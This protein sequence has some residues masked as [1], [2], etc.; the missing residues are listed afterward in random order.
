MGRRSERLD[1]FAIGHPSSYD[2]WPMLWFGVGWGRVEVTAHPCPDGWWMRC[3]R[4]KTGRLLAME[5]WPLQFVQDGGR[6]DKIQRVRN[7]IQRFSGSPGGG[8]PCDRVVD[9]AFREAYPVLSEYLVAQTFP[10]GAPRKGATITVF[11]AEDGLKG[12][13]NERD[14]GLM[15]WVTCDTFNGLWQALEDQLCSERVPWRRSRDWSPPK[16]PA[17]PGEPLPNG[18]P[19]RKK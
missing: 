18:K 8:G 14:Q 13:L 4:H 16:P 6:A 15:L 11:A 9:T 17:A 7:M 10:D 2:G 3:S 1:R 19:R 12:C 5:F